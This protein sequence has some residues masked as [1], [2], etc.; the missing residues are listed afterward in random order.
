VYGAPHP[1]PKPPPKDTLTALEW[2]W[3]DVLRLRVNKKVST[4]VNQR[5][6]TDGSA[7]QLHLLNYDFFDDKSHES[8]A[9]DDVAIEFD[10]GGRRVRNV[11]HVSPGRQSGDADI[12]W[13][14]KDSILEMSL[15]VGMYS[16]VHVQYEQ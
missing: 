1:R 15:N 7:H 3:K 8:I 6:K 14:V 4:V 11:R 13:Q 10:V 9:A 5:R 16:L 12:R 2:A